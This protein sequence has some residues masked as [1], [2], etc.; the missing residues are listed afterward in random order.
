MS[1][2]DDRG[3]LEAVVSDNRAHLLSS[4]PEGGGI[5]SGADG[6]GAVAGE[7]EAGR[8]FAPVLEDAQNEEADTA[9]GASRV[10]NQGSWAH[11][12]P[13]PRVVPN[14]PQVMF[15]DKIEREYGELRKRFRMKYGVEEL[16]HVDYDHVRGPVFVYERVRHSVYFQGPSVDRLPPRRSVPPPRAPACGTL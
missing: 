7:E 14:A 12:T 11:D 16:R 8:V 15:G 3:G 5:D 1:T 4:E 6:L 10:S 13:A 2:D 9:G